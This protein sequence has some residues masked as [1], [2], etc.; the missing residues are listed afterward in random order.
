MGG[1]STRKPNNP[2]PMSPLI[3]STCTLRKLPAVGARVFEFTYEE[4]RMELTLPLGWRVVSSDHNGVE[5]RY[6]NNPESKSTY[7]YHELINGVT[8]GDTCTIHVQQ[9]Q[10]SPRDLPWVIRTLSDKL[11]A[12]IGPD[13]APIGQTLLAAFRDCRDHRD[14]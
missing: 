11:A 10:S 7:T 14:S 4:Q 1:P 5:F 3:L 12:S 9:P 13:C 6:R 8:L 2:M